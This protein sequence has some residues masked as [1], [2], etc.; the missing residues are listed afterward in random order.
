MSEIQPATPANVLLWVD[1]TTRLDL[2]GLRELER[3]LRRDWSADSLGP[4]LS[5]IEQRRACLSEAREYPVCAYCGGPCDK[6][7]G[8]FAV[9]RW[10]GGAVVRR[11]YA[12]SAGCLIAVAHSQKDR[13]AASVPLTKGELPLVEEQ[14]GRRRMCTR[15]R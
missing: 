7:T 14:R 15:P 1:M 6:P 8:W 9:E 11:G 5:A 2:L 12:C 3:N 4:V 13:T 10:D